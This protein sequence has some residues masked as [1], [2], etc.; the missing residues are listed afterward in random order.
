MPWIK[1]KAKREVARVAARSP[2]KGPFYKSVPYFEGRFWGE[3]EY[4]RRGFTTLEKKPVCENQLMEDNVF[5]H[6]G[7]S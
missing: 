6:C 1:A 7:T 3:F 2:G 5:V 4:F